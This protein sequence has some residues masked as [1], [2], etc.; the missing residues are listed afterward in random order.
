MDSLPNEAGNTPDARELL[1]LLE[2]LVVHDSYQTEYD[3]TVI[4]ICPE[5][6]EQDGNHLKHCAFV[7]AR[8][9]IARARATRSP[10]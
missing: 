1:F 10:Q 8:S 4:T 3:G 5:C 7:R 2:E 9:V 6:G